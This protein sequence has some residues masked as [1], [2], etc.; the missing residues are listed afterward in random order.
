MD[1]TASFETH[2][3]HL[4]AIA[5]RMLGSAAEAEDVLQEAWLRRDATNATNIQSE[6]AWLSTVVTRLC[7]DKL[8]S[9]RAQ[10]EEYVGPW[11]PERIRT[12]ERVDPDSISMAFLVLLEQLTPVERAAYILREVFDYSHGEVAATLDVEEAT[13]RKIYQRARDRIREGRPRFSPSR[14][15]HERLLRTFAGA[16][17]NGDLSAL[18]QTLAKDAT[19]WADSGG[20]VPAAARR[21][22]HGAHEIAL[23]FTGLLRKFPPGPDQTF[24]VVDVNGW[25]A[26]V[27]RRTGAANLVL[28][29][30]S[31]GE[32]IVA[33]RN[34]VNP[35]K[36]QSI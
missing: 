7:L 12:E 22:L 35:E 1:R 17:M 26:L 11:L 36:L 29:I 4:F 27:G 2:R 15:E 30:E 31:D 6:K 34:V 25:P 18:E 16:M 14:A 24:E 23:F 13:C 33:I 32:K 8:K 20:K 10:R 21:P 5:Y 9:A 28:S 3:A 19:L